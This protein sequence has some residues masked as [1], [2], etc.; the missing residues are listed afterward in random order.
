M[1]SNHQMIKK[2]FCTVLLSFEAFSFLMIAPLI[3]R[4][5]IGSKVQNYSAIV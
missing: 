1:S 3:N 2:R 4:L 5:D